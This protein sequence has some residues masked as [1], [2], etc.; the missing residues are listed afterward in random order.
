M[1]RI[2]LILIFC[3][4]LILISGKKMHDYYVSVTVIEYSEKHKSLQIISQIFIDDF[5]KV[6]RERYDESLTLAED[7]EPKIVDSYMR[8]Y[9]AKK[10]KLKVNGEDVS[11]NFI[12]KEYIDDITYCYLE[13]EN[14]SEVKTL[15]VTNQTLFDVISEQ[16]NIVRMKMFGKNRSFLLFPDN[17]NCMLNFN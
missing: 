10:L 1:K 17:D 6:L 8:K 2:S 16:Q 14:I 11:F 13:V 15:E 5:E 4:S 9:L 3:F 12:G 7:D